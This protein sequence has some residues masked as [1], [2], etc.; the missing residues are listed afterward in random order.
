LSPFADSGASIKNCFFYHR[1]ALGRWDAISD[2]YT[3][4]YK[5][6]KSYFHDFIK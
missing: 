2:I 6:Y 4:S 1:H 5:S 3:F